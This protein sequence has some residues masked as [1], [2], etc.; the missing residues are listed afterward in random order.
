VACRNGS[1][2]TF[3]ATGGTTTYIQVTGGQFPGGGFVP[4]ELTF[5]LTPDPVAS[6]FFYPGSP[7]IFDTV[8]FS[9]TSFDPVKVGLQSETWDFGDGSAAATG[10]C[11]TH[12]YV[13]D[14]TYHATLTVVTVD[15][16]TAVAARDI[17]VRTHDVA[18][19]KVSVPDSIKIG[20][21]KPVAVGIGNSR[22][23]ETVQVQ[24]M[25]SVAGGGWQQVGVLTQYVPVQRGS[26]VVEFGFNYTASP[27]DAL[28][29][30]ITF[31]VVATIQ[32]APDAIP[33]DNTFI[34][35]PVKVTT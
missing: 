5:D 16:R 10:C 27:D 29:G 8:Q 21:T 20:K 15:G 19:Q 7:S 33:A 17:E 22:Y 26:H 14:G 35:L 28:V 6:F 30:K 11:P 12:G 24:L 3:R 34:S 9:D 1:S 18:I 4:F 2:L 23:A 32:G 31:Q 25:K 13:V